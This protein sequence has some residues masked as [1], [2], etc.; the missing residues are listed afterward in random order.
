MPSVK[1]LKEPG[2]LYDL[3]YLFYANFNSQI[4]VDGIVD[5]TKRDS[6]KQYLRET[7]KLFGEIP[8]ELYVFY[9]AVRNNR[10]FM[11]TYYMDPYKNHFATDFNFKYLQNELKDTDQLTKNLIRFYFRDL[12]EEAVES[13]FSSPP[14][15]FETIK[16]SKYSGEEKSKLYEFF[17]DPEAYCQT[18]QYELMTKEVA[19]S[20]YYKERYEIILEAHKNNTFDKLCES[21]GELRDLSFL[22]D[23]EQTLHTSFCL[24]NKYHM[25]LLFIDYGAIYLLGYDY[26]S[27]LDALL[28]T[29]TTLGLEDLCGALS[30][31]S[32][33]KMLHFLKERGE[34]TCK[35][36]EK[37]FHFSG[38]TAYHHITL[39][40]KV[41]AVKVRNEG[42]TIYYSL[43]K[44]FFEQM[45]QQFSKFCDG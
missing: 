7:L 28:H 1:L 36:I 18:L 19:L 14:Q 29:K 13:C 33:V 39:L 40:T 26:A 27:I 6:Y 42:K 10:C 34:A 2:F 24:L 41:G 32:R 5:P 8:E 22:R 45:K 16:R 12:S 17:H 31:A 23:G 15:V 44:K 3:H 30:E 9:H 20:S 21:V 25:H 4:C 43:N 38:S 37:I 35:D 11:T